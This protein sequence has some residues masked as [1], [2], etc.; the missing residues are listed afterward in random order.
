MPVVV[1]E[2]EA[3]E[4]WKK[5]QESWLKQNPDYMK[6]IPAALQEAAM[7]KAGLQKDPGASVAENG[8]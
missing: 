1:D 4:Q 7:I 5:S 6:K 8:K 3:F 2:P